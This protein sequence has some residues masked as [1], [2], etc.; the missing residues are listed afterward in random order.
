MFSRF[1]WYVLVVG[2]AAR[3]RKALDMDARLANADAKA[4]YV[5]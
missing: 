3:R 1:G 4:I 5:E 2:L